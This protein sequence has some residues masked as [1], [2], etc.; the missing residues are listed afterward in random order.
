MTEQ[1]F[2]KLEKR[3]EEMLAHIRKKVEEFDA[4]SKEYYGHG[5]VREAINDMS[6]ELWGNEKRG[7]Q[8]IAQRLDEQE[9]YIEES[10][11][12]IRT[13]RGVLAFFGLTT[14]ASIIGLISWLVKAGA[15]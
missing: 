8:G 10:K 5:G 3:L 4:L 2:Q 13:L 14:L 6:L 7:R 11:V 9:R 1:E 15:P 12:V